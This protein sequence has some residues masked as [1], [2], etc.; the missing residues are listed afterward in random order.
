MSVRKLFQKIP[1]LLPRI[2]PCLL[3]SP[4]SVAQYLD[5]AHPPFDVVVFDEASQIPVWDAVGAIARGAQAVIVGDP[6]QL[7]PTSFFQRGD[8]DDDDFD[9]DSDNRRGS[10]EHP[11]RLHRARASPCFAPTGTTEA[12]TRASSRSATI[13]TTTIACSR[14]RRRSATAWACRGTHVA[15]GVYD[16]GKSRT[17]RVEADRVVAE[18]VRRLRDPDLSRSL[19]RRRDVQHRPAAAHRRP[20]RTRCAATRRR[21]TCSS[22]TRCPSR[23]SS[24][25]SRTSRAMSAA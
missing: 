11:R 3:T 22:P 17:N 23:C 13:I 10:R 2:T 19:H 21:S 15:D 8:D 9:D 1:N 24:R 14:S 5:A 12:V 20:A 18:I 6:K 16:K 4:M 7:P 25:T